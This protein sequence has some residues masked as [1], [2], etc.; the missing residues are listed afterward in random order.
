MSWTRLGRLFCAENQFPW[1]VSHAANPFPLP[2]QDGRLLVL[3]NSRDAE[4]RSH[5]AGLFLDP[6]LPAEAIELIDRPLL[7]PGV[8]GAF[9][10]SGV[11]IGNCLEDEQGQWRLYYLGWTLGRRTAFYNSIGLAYSRDIT[12][13][14]ERANLAPVL[15][16]CPQEPFSL[17]YPWV[18][19]QGQRWSMVYGATIRWLDG[20]RMVHELHCADAE[21]GIAWQP[22]GR[23]LL[24]LLA[25]EIAH[26]RPCLLVGTRQE[27]WFSVKT[28]RGYHIGYAYSE[29]GIHWQRADGYAGLFPG[30]A[31]WENAEVCYPCVIDFRG[32]RYLFYCGNGYGRTGFGLAR[33][34]Q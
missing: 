11:S 3:F 5:V 16:R 34:R 8:L 6:Q 12:Q 26:S 17:S 7:S 20:Q 29:D 21:D 22:S 24:P 28:A 32:E 14:F 30:Q 2:W 10:E 9:D 25:G 23:P 4:G 18:V 19:R 1:L 15:S 31:D 27:L 33:W 13:G